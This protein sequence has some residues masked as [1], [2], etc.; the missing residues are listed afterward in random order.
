MNLNSDIICHWKKIC[1][2]S[3]EN[4]LERAAKEN[5]KEFQQYLKYFLPK[6]VRY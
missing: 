2:Y 3:A 5:N 1:Y 4:L 6:A